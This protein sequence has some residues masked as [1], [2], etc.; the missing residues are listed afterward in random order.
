MILTAK[1]EEG[2]KIAVARYKNKEPW[3]CISGYAGSGKTTLVKHI[4]EALDLDPEDDVCYVAYTGKAANVLRSK[5]NPNAK[6]L[7]KLIYKTEMRNDKYVS[8]LRTEFEQPYK[9]I[10]LDEVSMIPQNMWEELLGFGVYVLACGDPGQLPPISGTQASVI[11]KPHIFLDEIMR[12]AQESEIIRLS[13]LVREGKE[14]PLFKGNEVQ[15]FNRNEL[16][17]GMLLW[18]DQV[19]CATNNNKIALNKNIRKQ[20]GYTE[21]FVVGEKII[22][23]S[24]Q[25][26]T[27]SNEGTPLTNG[28]IL[29]VNSITPSEL[30]YSYKTN[31]NPKVIPISY[32]NATSEVNEMYPYLMLDYNALLT[33]NDTFDI[34][35]IIAIRKSRDKLDRWKVPIHFDYGY[36][37]TTWKAQG[38]EWDNVLLLEENHPFDTEEHIKYMYTGITRASKKLVIIKK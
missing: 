32:I 37:I 8:I 19:L 27:L 22:C 7:H 2:L 26:E 24:N 31:V 23:Q 36:A 3:T 11:Q 17:E 5:G 16:N 1:Q 38:S 18:A 6:T 21:D 4:I 35:S 29:T 9:V 10:V 13:M 30:Y 33:G 14:L 28:T 20:L 34:S 12:Q 15:V 25:W